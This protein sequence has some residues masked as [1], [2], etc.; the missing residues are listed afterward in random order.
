[1]KKPLLCI[2]FFIFSF[3][4]VSC[5]E[6][7]KF[8]E[9][10]EFHMGTLIT[11]KI[12]GKNREKASKEIMKKIDELE[13]LM[14][15]N[16]SGGDINRLNEASGIK[17]IKLNSETIF[18]LENALKYSEILGG[19]FDVT[20]GPLVK[21]WGIITDNPRVPPQDEIDNLLS[22]VNY[23]NLK[24]D[25]K[26]LTAEL[27]K[28][29]QIVDLGGITKGYAGDAAVEICRKN[30]IKSAYINLG[31][32]VVV[33]GKKPDGSLWK[34]AIQNPRADNS[35]YIAILNVSD[36]SV[37][38][39]GD[40]ERHFEKNGKRYHHILD[41]KTGYPSD[42]GLI[43]V[44]IVT[45]KSIQ[46]DALSKTFVLGLKKGMELIQKIPDAEA[47]FVTSDKKVYIT[48][49]LKDKFT[50]SDKSGQFKFISN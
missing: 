45:K 39:S 27:L 5:S 40:Y 22:L 17:R 6:D 30:D 25:S 14:T 32:N 13:S 50:F 46:A 18:V 38:T 15:I 3:V 28:K 7:E 34:I 23:K 4:L 44:T 41:P 36:C 35:S 31:G 49:G 48:K 42:S 12:F 29:G 11:Q 37:V 21:A 10:Q 20:I 26:N 9:A 1:M 8:I 16:K 43:S 24:V 2:Y 19:A 47:V 33:V